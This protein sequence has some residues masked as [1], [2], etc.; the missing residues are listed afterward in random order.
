MYILVLTQL[1]TWPEPVA[2]FPTYLAAWLYGAKHCRG[3][4]WE[5]ES[6]I[7]E[8]LTPGLDEVR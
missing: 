8:D 3:T 5:I 2:T 7:P 4:W 6:I 1:G